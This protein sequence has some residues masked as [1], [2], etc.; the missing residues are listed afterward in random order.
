MYPKDK[1]SNMKIEPDSIGSDNALLN[2]AIAKTSRP[3]LLQTTSCITVKMESSPDNTIE[4]EDH[5][6]LPSISDAN[7]VDQGCP[8][9]EQES[10]SSIQHRLDINRTQ[11]PSALV[12]EHDDI[13]DTLN[14]EFYDQQTYEQGV[15]SQVDSALNNNEDEDSLPTESHSS[16]ITNPKLKLLDI[17]DDDREISF[18]DREAKQLQLTR[19]E[20]LAK[21]SQAD[22][23]SPNQ[24]YLKFL[25]RIPK[26]IRS[27]GKIASD[28][29]DLQIIKDKHTQP[30]TTKIANKITNEK[31]N[32]STRK[33]SRD[34]SPDEQEPDNNDI[35]SD[36]DVNIYSDET[37]SEHEVTECPK[38]K[39]KKR[40]VDDG[41]YKYYQRRMKELAKYKA[42]LKLDNILPD[43]TE[44]KKL[45]QL[46]TIDGN[47]KIPEEIWHNLYEYQQT[48]VRWLW[49]L[50]QLGAG[51]II[52][53]EMGL[54]KT[55]QVIAFLSAL[56]NSVIPSYRKDYEQL[57]PIVLVCPATVMH[58]WLMEFRKWWPPF[59]VA[60]LH[61]TG[62]FSG[63]RKLL[64]ENMNKARGILITSYQGAV[65][66]QDALHAFD[67][68]YAILD[69][70]HKIRNP[71]AQVTL[72][73]KRFRTPHRIIMSGSPIQNNLKELWSVFDYIYPGKLGTL[74]VFME[75]FAIPITQGGYANATD[76]QLQ[77]AYKC[78][79]V[80][81]D[82]IKPYL[83]RRTKN[84]VKDRLKLPERSEQVLFCKLTPHQRKMYQAYLDSPAVKDIRNGSCKIFVGLIH[85][86]KI[87]NHPDLFD[88]TEC[89]LASQNDP[90]EFEK[91]KTLH[92]GYYK[93]SGK[94]MVVDALLRL[95]KKQNQKVL[96]FSQSKQMLRILKMHLESRQY[97]F[98]IMD[99]G[100]P[101]G[102]RQIL[103]DKF[104]KLPEIFIF[105]LTT[106]VGGI[107]VNLTG[108]N[109]IIIFDPDWNPSTDMQARER[110][111]RIG[112]NRQVTIYRLITAGTIEE[113]I[114]HRQVFKL[115]LTNRILKDTKQKR[116][117][118]T[119]DLHE[120]FTLSDND[121]NIETNALF[122]ADL[123]ISAPKTASDKKNK[124]RKIG[125]TSD[126]IELSEDKVNQMRERVKQ[127]SKMIA[128]KYNGDGPSKTTTHVSEQSK[129]TKGDLKPS[130]SKSLEKTVKSNKIRVDYLVKQDMYRVDNDKIDEKKDLTDSQKDDYI[131]RR[132][133]KKSDIQ[134]A[135][136]HDKI[137]SDAGS[138]YKIIESE[139]HKVAMDAIKALK[140]S[141]RACLGAS[142]GIPNWTGRNGQISVENSLSRFRQRTKVSTTG[143]SSQG[144]LLSAI[145]KRNFMNPVKLSQSNRPNADVF[146]ADDDSD[147]ETVGNFSGFDST[148]P[149]FRVDEMADEIRTF[150]SFRAAK[151]GEA[152][153]NEL[154][155]FFKN[156][157]HP[158]KTPIFKAILHK[159]C[160]FNRRN[161]SGFWRLK[162]EFR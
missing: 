24:D 65:I 40:L 152:E 58:Q 112:Q 119:N 76:V 78:A 150:I 35:T 156:K 109:R 62:S 111:W 53:D 94:M 39:S 138:D 135:L 30:T 142:S 41:D 162:S 91:N 15:F 127:L 29:P 116:F 105:L 51:G 122:D 123:Q 63:K 99:G 151:D 145:K 2:H 113:K 10:L 43:G 84:E 155:Q 115:Y 124:K 136:H 12:Q 110:A 118:K 19:S 114:Y 20:R 131:L 1:D 48:G 106:R 85:L 147:D 98:L 37:S 158:S 74:P 23:H 101:I 149:E 54:G 46:Y 102:S 27:T 132:L 73:C 92:Y 52:G 137:E 34:S 87:C 133:F 47:F 90:L 26:K 13:L 36:G 103:V 89:E 31:L 77:V 33:R 14:I 82:A 97:S 18:E 148:D 68:H 160:D 130:T 57:G 25:P 49:E 5:I 141:R 100:T 79:C 126:K 32:Q 11:I 64:V 143:G 7:L 8:T 157:F 28:I 70:G 66:Y 144:S 56:R 71:D 22:S 125:N 60:I 44:I 86:R 153:T 38:S 120:L 140:A 108:A 42:Q 45:D 72:A 6:L 96:L 107:G 4:A 139:A 59:R 9:P 161:N 55:I 128:D 21:T 154:L 129:I 69:E 159:L 61:S 17:I 3:L 67:W 75:H 88:S 95:W 146:G 81:R 121:K 93:K 80:L 16:G 117:F 134:G 50:H 83:L 104:N